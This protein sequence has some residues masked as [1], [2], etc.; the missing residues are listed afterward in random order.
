MIIDELKNEIRYARKKLTLI[1]LTMSYTI[2]M[3]INFLL[4]DLFVASFIALLTSIF[5]IFFVANKYAK[6]A[7]KFDG[8]LMEAASIDLER[9]YSKK[10][11]FLYVLSYILII[12]LCSLVS[13]ITLEALCMSMFSF[14]IIGVILLI[15]NGRSDRFLNKMPTEQYKDPHE[16]SSANIEPYKSSDWRY[17]AFNC[18]GNSI[19]PNL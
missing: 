14:S 6:I 9:T 17:S 12:T 15:I 5:T 1:T 16:W 3:V 13:K 8:L 10:S 4:K 2:L 18:P 7:D 11:I 19:Y